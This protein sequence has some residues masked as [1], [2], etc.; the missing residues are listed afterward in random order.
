M[1]TPIVASLLALCV[2]GATMTPVAAQQASGP[3]C[4]QIVEFAEVIEL[5]VLPT[6][7]GQA[8][9]TGKS[10]TFEDSY[11][12][13]A[14]VILDGEFIT[15]TAVNGFLPGM[16]GGILQTTT[17]DGFGTVTFAD[18]NQTQNLEFKAFAPPCVLQ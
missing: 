18:N 4:L 17:G 10:L 2:L 7:G 16:L 1:K 13:S 12:G 8:I 9:L 11:S 15:F 6:G 3:V 5:F 14:A